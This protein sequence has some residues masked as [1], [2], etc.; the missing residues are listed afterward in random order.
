MNTGAEF[1]AC[2]FTEETL[3]TIFERCN[4]TATATLRLAIM[5]ST[6]YWAQVGRGTGLLQVLRQQG[7]RH[8][9]KTKNTFQSSQQA[10]I[11]P[12]LHGQPESLLRELRYQWG[13]LRQDGNLCF[14]GNFSSKFAL[15]IQSSFCYPCLN[16]WLFLP[17]LH[18]KMF[19]L[20]LALSVFHM[21]FALLMYKW[22]HPT[23]LEKRVG[24]V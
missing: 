6:T 11:W 14:S 3:G 9:R 4:W 16:F 5:H 13:R 12:P 8:P 22:G 19:A 1:L 20:Y 10:D 23:P 24:T 2:F 21:F 15:V 17:G 18:E 7:E